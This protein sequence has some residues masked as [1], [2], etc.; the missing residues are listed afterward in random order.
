MKKS[1]LLAAVAAAL[2]MTAGAVTAADVAMEDCKVVKD[3]K[4][5][6]KEGKGDCKTAKNSC[7]GKNK[8]G[9]AD[10]WIKVPKGQCEKMN[11]GDFSGVSADVKAK[12]EGAK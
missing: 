5:I 1:I 4:N 8:V 12:V 10:A 3:G 2:T 7:A 9:D 11:K 6:V